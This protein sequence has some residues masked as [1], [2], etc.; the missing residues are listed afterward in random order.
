[1]IIS[2]CH[3]YKFLLFDLHYFDT[4]EKI[5]KKPKYKKVN[6]KQGKIFK[7]NNSSNLNILKQIDPKN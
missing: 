2:G 7:T 3:D 6:H 4:R 5:E 1:M